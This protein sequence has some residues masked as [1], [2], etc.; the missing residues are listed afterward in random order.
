MSLQFMDRSVVTMKLADYSRSSNE[1]LLIAESAMNWIFGTFNHGGQYD[2]M[3]LDNTVAPDLITPD[4]SNHRYIFYI[5]ED[6]Q[7]RIGLPDILQRVAD[8]EARNAGGSIVNQVVD[9]TAS[10]LLV[11]D[12][13]QNGRPL[14]FEKTNVF[15]AAPSLNWATS[16]NARAAA[17]I[18]AVRDPSQP[19]RVLFYAQAVGQYETSRSYVQRFLGSYSDTMNRNIGAINGENRN[20]L[21][22]A[23]SEELE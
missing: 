10:T 19:S 15:R 9:G 17:W 18:E 2:G 12:L 21:P 6:N 4:L 22:K 8:G 1:S 3:T 23:L 11:Q 20:A 14:L 5:R 16:R 13:L 7:I